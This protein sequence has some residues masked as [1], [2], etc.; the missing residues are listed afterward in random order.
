MK[1]LRETRGNMTA[2]EETKSKETKAKETKKRVKDARNS[3]SSTA[4]EQSALKRLEADG[5]T[6][7]FIVRKKNALFCPENKNTYSPSDLK[8]LASLRTEGESDPDDMAVVYAIEA[9]DGTRGTLTDAFGLYADPKVGE[10][11]KNIPDERKKT[12]DLIQEGVY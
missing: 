1:G 2:S 6:N 12:D 7:R 5:F 10:F 11:M 3:A 9:D 8:L 4:T